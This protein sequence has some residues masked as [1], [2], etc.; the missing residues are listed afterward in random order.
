[1]RTVHV[2]NWRQLRLLF[3]NRDIYSGLR[4]LFFSKLKTREE[5]EGGHEKRKGKGG[6]GEKKK[7][8]IKNTLKY[9]YEA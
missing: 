7:R 3:Q 6:K 2:K 4:G 9:L 5:F 1:M 8:V